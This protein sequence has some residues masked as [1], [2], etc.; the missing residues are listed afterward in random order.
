MIFLVSRA[1]LR[2]ISDTVYRSFRATF[3]K[4][5]VKPFFQ[6]DWKTIYPKAEIWGNTV[7]VGAS[8]AEIV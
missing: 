1:N 3:S 8:S 6:S 7:D 5:T 4:K 2:K